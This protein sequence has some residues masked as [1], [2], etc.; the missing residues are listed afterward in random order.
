MAKKDNR[1]KI[2][3]LRHAESTG[4][5]EGYF[6]GQ[7]DFPL[8]QRGHEQAYALADRWKKEKREFD[9]IIASPLSRTRETAEIISE[10]LNLS[11]DEFDPIW[12]ERHNGKLTGMKHE[13]GRAKMP[14]PRFRNPYQTFADNGEG[15]WELFLRAG[16]ALQSLIMRPSGRYLIV[17][18]GAI[19]NFTMKAITGVAPHANYQG[20]QFRFENTAFA[21]TSYLPR[22]HRWYIEGL[23]DQH[24]W[25]KND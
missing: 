8:T 16:Q 19:L 2:V 7:G 3:F 11:I 23:N 24:H 17:S 15:D 1:Y 5:A 22:S 12:M 9:Y 13:V 4:N 20:P 25:R 10:N 14:Q 18:H 6:Q 21:T